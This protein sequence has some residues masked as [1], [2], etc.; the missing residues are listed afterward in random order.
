MKKA[1]KIALAI[2]VGVTLPLLVLALFD[3]SLALILGLFWLIATGG[4]FGIIVSGILDS[5]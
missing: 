3:P 5:N 2:E 4:L 1:T